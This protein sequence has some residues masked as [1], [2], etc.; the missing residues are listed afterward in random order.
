MSCSGDRLIAVRFVAVPL[1]ETPSPV[2]AVTLDVIHLVEHT[3]GSIRWSVTTR[4]VTRTCVHRRL[5]VPRRGRQHL[6][7]QTHIAALLDAV[8]SKLFL[9]LLGDEVSPS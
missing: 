1:T 4:Q 8:E 7:R 6:R 3:P 2:G 5:L 9:R